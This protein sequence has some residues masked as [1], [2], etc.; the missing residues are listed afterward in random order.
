LDS[1]E[2][3]EISLMALDSQQQLMLKRLRDA[4][5]QSVTF[6]ALRADGI[7]FPATIASE[8]ELGGRRRR[9]RQLPAKRATAGRR[10]GDFVSRNMSRTRQI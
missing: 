10:G 3:D 5:G 4:G 7:S 9:F 2:G 1:L 6:A 8:L